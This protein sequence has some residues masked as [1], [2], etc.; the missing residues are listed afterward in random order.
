MIAY[1]AMYDKLEGNFEGCEVT[2]ISR[3]S[4]EKAD[5]L[6][7]LAPGACQYRQEFSSRRYLSALSR[8]S[9]PSTRR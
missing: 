4:N 5:N 9:Q 8:S 6:P 7:T 2:H 3:E 1:R